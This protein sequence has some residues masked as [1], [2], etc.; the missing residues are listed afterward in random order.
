LARID[1]T[2]TLFN[3]QTL[4]GVGTLTGGLVANAGSTV[5]PGTNSIGTLTL[6]GAATFAGTNF[7]EINKSSTND[8]VVAGGA[9]TY[10]G[11][12]VLANLG[13][14]YAAGDSFKIFTGA[15]YS[16]AFTLSPASPG[17]GLAWDTSSLTI[18]GTLKV[19]AAVSTPPTIQSIRVTGGNVILTGTNNTGA[20][21][22]YR[23]LTSTNVAVPLTNWVLLTNGTFDGAGQFSSTNPVTG[24]RQQFY[25]LQVP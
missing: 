18:D 4:Q 10:G 13:P 12:L 9:V 11:T 21:G 6:S 24:N 20:G 17:A 2:L 23:V 3:G 25:S 15:S 22:T 16:G 14:A 19:A 1:A 5:S 7:I 8:Q